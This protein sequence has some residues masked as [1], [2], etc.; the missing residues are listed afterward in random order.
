MTA[1]ALRTWLMSARARRLSTRSCGIPQ[2]RR[3]RLEHLRVYPGR[4]SLEELRRNCG[5]YMEAVGL[6]GD[7]A[8]VS[9][10]SNKIRQLIISGCSALE[11]E[12][13][14]Q[15]VD[16]L[17]LRAELRRATLL[18]QAIDRHP[19]PETAVASVDWVDDFR[20]SE[21]RIQREL[22]AE[23]YRWDLWGAAHL[24]GGGG[25][26]DNG[27]DDSR[28]WLLTQGRATWQGAFRDPDSL[29]APPQVRG[30]PPDLRWLVRGLVPVRGHVV[31][32]L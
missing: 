12:E 6:R 24:L 25:C 16:R 28:G 3:C 5:I 29:A 20:G 30:L 4:G 11:A 27:F 14:R 8:A 10:G 31:R 32:H 18:I 13:M 22:L 23:S 21:P 17:G 15:L 19:W 9:L 2:R 1:R 26:S 7:L